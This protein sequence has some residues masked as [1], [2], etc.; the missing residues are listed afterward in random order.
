ML[1]P[2][3]AAQTKL[4]EVVRITAPTDSG[5]LVGDV[6]EIWV[7]DQAREVLNLVAELPGDELRRC[8]VPGYGI[9]AHSSADLLFE[10]AF[11]FRRHGALLLGAGVPA[12]LRRIQG[13]D[14][15]S[16]PG[17]NFSNASVPAPGGSA[18]GRRTW[19][20]PARRAHC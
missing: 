18:R 1:L 2:E 14:P 9:R 10:I 15:D 6:L 16:G 20:V 17:A 4:I 7:E 3:T 12:G 19:W 13:F 5:T 8:F 11:C